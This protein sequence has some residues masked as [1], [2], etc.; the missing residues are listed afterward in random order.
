M[1]T[2]DV[3]REQVGARQFVKGIDNPV[4]VSCIAVVAIILIG[5]IY[6]PDFASVKYLVQQLR[7]ASF[8]GIVATGAMVVILLGQIDLSIPWAM[9]A[10]AMV[11][12]AVVGLGEAWAPFAIPAGLMVGVV[13]GLFNGIG[14]GYVR[15]PSM[16]LTLATNAVLLGLAVVYTGGFAPQT[17][18]SGL[19]RWLGRDSSVLGVP[20]VLWVWLLLGVGVAV[21][22]RRSAVGRAIFATGNREVASYLSGIRTSRV[23]CLA[24]VFSGV[25]SALGGIL[26]AGRLDQSYQGMG[27]DYLLP[28]IAAVVLGGTHILGGR[29][30]YLGTAVGVLVISL[31]SSVLAVMQIPEASRQIIYGAV[32]IAMLLLHGRGAAPGR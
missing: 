27:N 5:S 18:A 21:V 14:V 31:I 32:I 20:N 2:Q 29:G 13:V 4:L 19:M 16:I 1:S 22:L 23:I 6:L 26:L 25:C 17:K 3:T 30:T 8:L 15:L 24:F 12:T 10:A 28:A 7:I 9:T 11:S